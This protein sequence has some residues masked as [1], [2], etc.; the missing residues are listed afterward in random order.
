M[1]GDLKLTFIQKTL[2]DYMQQVTEVMQVAARRNKVNKTGE[3]MKSLAYTAIQQ[4]AGGHATLSFKEY[5]RFVD[6]GV[7]RGHPLGGLTTMK[8]T[9]QS[10]NREGLAQVKDKVRKPKKIYAKPAYGR[11]GWMYNKL[12]YGYTEETIAMLKK[13][14]GNGES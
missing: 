12:L 11:L 3:G 1:N 7:G 4:G 5:L 6:M 8:V 2:A 9:L 14:M 13:E 10:S